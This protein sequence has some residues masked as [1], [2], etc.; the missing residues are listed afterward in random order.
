MIIIAMI[1]FGIAF[2]CGVIWNVIYPLFLAHSRNHHTTVWEQL[3]CPKYLEVRYRPVNAIM[4]FLWQRRYL[5]LNDQELAGLGVGWVRI[6]LLGAYLGAA[7]FIGFG[8]LD[9]LLQTQ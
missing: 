8:L 2:V 4:Q 7:G 1:S 5:A 3:H 6:A 9:R